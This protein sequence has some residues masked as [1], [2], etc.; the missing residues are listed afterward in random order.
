MSSRSIS[1]AS[2]VSKGSR[3]GVAGARCHGAESTEAVEEAGEGRENARWC[4]VMARR[5]KK[6]TTPVVRRRGEDEEEEAVLLG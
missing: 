1:S 3:G 4:V 6:L 5:V 2:F